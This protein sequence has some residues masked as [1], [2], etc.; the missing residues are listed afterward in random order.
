MEV[1]LYGKKIL[2]IITFSLISLMFLLTFS[3]MSACKTG[4]T[5]NEAVE[6]EIE[7]EGNME[8]I[9]DKDA[10]IKEHEKSDDIGT[11]PAYTDATAEEVK[12]NVIDKD[13]DLFI[14]DVSTLYDDGHIPGAVNYPVGDGSLDAVIP[15]LDPKGKYLV[16]CHSDSASILGAQ[17][18]V[19]AGFKSVIRLSGNFQAWVDAG[20]EVEKN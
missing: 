1:D 5:T 9:K 6:S 10:D 16:Y 12:K 13:P 4:E 20:Y 17:K 3:F 19:D 11:A 7:D 8:P 15:D 2:K 18:L 14:I